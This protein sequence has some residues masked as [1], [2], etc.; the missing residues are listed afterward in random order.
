MPAVRPSMDTADCDAA[1]LMS[2]SQP[3]NRLR[4][5]VSLYDCFEALQVKHHVQIG[6]MESCTMSEEVMKSV[7]CFYCFYMEN[8][9]HM[10]DP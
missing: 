9:L 1:V 7:H 6:S 3:V 5:A 2:L 8:I 10:I 4:G